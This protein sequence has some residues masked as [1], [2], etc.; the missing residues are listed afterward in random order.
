MHTSR[1]L[2]VPVR[3]FGMKRFYFPSYLKKK[4]NNKTNNINKTKN[5]KHEPNVIAVKLRFIT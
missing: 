2:S 3:Q 4:Q 5:Q 1:S